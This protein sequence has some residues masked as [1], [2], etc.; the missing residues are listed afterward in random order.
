MRLS[1]S[2][3]LPSITRR[4]R[5]R[6]LMLGVSLSLVALI[7]WA[8]FVLAHIDTISHLYYLAILLAAT[9]LGRR[10]A[11]AIAVFAV[12]LTHLAD[13]ELSQLHYAEADVMEL[14]LFLTVAIVASRLSDNARELRRL[15]STDDLTGLH[16]LRSFEAISREL[17][18]R[19]RA[20]GG[21]I[22]MLCLDVDHLKQLNDTHGH[23]TGADAV[24]HVGKVIAD[25][26]ADTLPG[27]ADACRYGGDEFAIVIA[28]D[29]SA[30]S[31]SLAARIQDTVAAS[32][33]TLDSKAF[34]AG[35]LS[36]SV[37]CSSAVVDR[38][39]P[40]AAIFTQLFR[41]ADEAMYV[42]KRGRR[43]L[44]RAPDPRAADGQSPTGA[45]PFSSVAGPA[46]PALERRPGENP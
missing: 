5:S 3:K 17:I 2:N 20:A 37:G 40:A 36:V 24:K 43:T 35:T 41:Q 29:P 9:Q 33:L 8:D 27:E 39:T 10:Y 15:A 32:A 28:E 19:Q 30:R 12:V 18:E 16:N 7:A 1:D 25:V 11:I 26:I 44:C 14:L 46:E 22:A 45:A 13:P 21:A 23:L 34:P 38:T 6:P 4:A 42:N 31:R